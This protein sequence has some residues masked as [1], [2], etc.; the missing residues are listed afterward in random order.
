MADPIEIDEVPESRNSGDKFI[1]AEYVLEDGTQVEA[2]VE[3]NDRDSDS[4]LKTS[5]LESGENALHVTK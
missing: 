3:N 5:D 2:K 4:E 1:D